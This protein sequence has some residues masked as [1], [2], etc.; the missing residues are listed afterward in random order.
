MKT[1]TGILFLLL[2]QSTQAT[3]TSE[4]IIKLQIKS[5]D[6]HLADTTHKSTVIDGTE[7]QWLN[8]SERVLVG[9]MAHNKA[10]A[11][12]LRHNQL[13]HELLRT[14]YYEAKRSG[15]DPDLVLAIIRVE[16]NFRKY[17]I[18]SVG[19]RGYM[20]IMVF[21]A[22][23]VGEQSSDLFN[24][25]TNLRLGCAILRSYLDKENGNVNRALAR[26]NGSLGKNDYPNLIYA[27]WVN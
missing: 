25:K 20:Q 26:Y 2:A 21:W 16:S 14:I 23:I 19:A 1:L 15:L 3:V 11:E 10:L 17:A 5:L 8:K 18:S 13:R 27:A 7:N 24:I 4:S 9:L 22:D 6:V 12:R